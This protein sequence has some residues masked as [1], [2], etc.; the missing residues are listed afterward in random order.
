[1]TF[2][3]IGSKIFGVKLNKAEQAVL[4]AQVK[5][6]VIELDREFSMDDDSAILYMLHTE[7]GFGKDRLFRAWQLMYQRAQEL[8][9]YYSMEQTD[10]GWL[11]RKKLLDIGVD[12]EEWYNNAD[13]SAW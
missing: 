3:K 5:Q 8:R 7:F 10:E 4:D 1:M 2:T 13:R 9:E 6:R 11:C 12:V